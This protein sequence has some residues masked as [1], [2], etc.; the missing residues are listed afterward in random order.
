MS[1]AEREKKRG[2]FLRKAVGHRDDILTAASGPR[3][4]GQMPLAVY[5]AAP[6]QAGWSSMTRGVERNGNGRV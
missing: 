4:E 1:K 3:D 5:R 2:G 6:T